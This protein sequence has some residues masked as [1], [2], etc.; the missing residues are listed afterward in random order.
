M[1][2]KPIFA[3]SAQV[4]ILFPTVPLKEFCIIQ[5]FRILPLIDK[6]YLVTNRLGTQDKPQPAIMWSNRMR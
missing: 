6:V 5:V 1:I 2:Q 4:Q 3:L